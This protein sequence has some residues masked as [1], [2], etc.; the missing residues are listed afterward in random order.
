MSDISIIIPTFNREALLRRTLESVASVV[1]ATDAVEIII[2]DNGSTDQSAKVC[3]ILKEKFCRLEWRYFYEDMPGLLSGRH[4]GAAEARGEVLAY[5]DDD[6]VLA[7]TWL[8]SLKDAFQDPGVALVGGPSLPFYDVP[9]PAWAK[10]LWLEVEEGLICGSLSLI[11]LGKAKKVIDPRFVWGVNLSIRKNIFRECEGFHPDCIPKSLQRYQGDGETGLT[12]KV[13]EKRLPAVYHPG[14][15]VAHII[16]ASR[17]TPEA[18]EQR[19]FYQGVCDSYTRI[20]R[21]G[22]AT[23]SRQKSW[24]DLVGATKWKLERQTIVRSPTSENILVLVGRARTAGARFHQNEVQ[25]DPGLLEWV[26]K[27]NYL[28]YSLPEGW[29]NYASSA[30]KITKREK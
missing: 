24:R 5:L 23:K 11:D 9:P 13:K 8:E 4:R 1:S 30:R 20:R 10:A 19:A 29:Q 2:V 25:K 7:P 28:D 18:L 27:P 3:Q 26:L 21:D 15:A 14:V 12:L 17:L 16:P 6:A 22:F